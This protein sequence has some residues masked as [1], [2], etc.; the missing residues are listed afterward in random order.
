MGVIGMK[1][2]GGGMLVRAGLPPAALL[3]WALSTPVTVVTVGCGS[4]AELEENLAAVAAGPL[5]PEEAA[6]L[7]AAIQPYAGQ[8]AYYRGVL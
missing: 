5:P 8:A 6:P 1:V 7:L 4:P 2:L 3:R